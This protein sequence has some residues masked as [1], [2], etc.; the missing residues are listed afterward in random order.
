MRNKLVQLYVR[1]YRYQTSEVPCGLMQRTIDRCLKQAQQAEATGDS[2]MLERAS[3][4]LSV[5]EGLRE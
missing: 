2:E 1:A 5:I 3:K 4:R